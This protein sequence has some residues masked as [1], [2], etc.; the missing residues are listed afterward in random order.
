MKLLLATVVAVAGTVAAV[1][2]GGIQ[3]KRESPI[4]NEGSDN[5]ESC[6]CKSHPL[7]SEDGKPVYQPTPRM[8][9]S[10][11][12]GECVP[13]VQCTTTQPTH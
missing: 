11:E 9:C 4:V 8:E 5:T 10:T 1:A 7:S 3:P 6:C 2:C 12:Q 13:N